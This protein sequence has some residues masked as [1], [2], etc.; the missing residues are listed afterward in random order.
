MQAQDNLKLL[1]KAPPRRRA[2]Y[3]LPLSIVGIIVLVTLLAPVLAPYDPRHAIPDRALHP[4]SLEYLFGT[5]ALGRDV[6]SRTLWGGRQT[7]GVALLAMAITIL[8]GLPV[9]VIAGYYGGW[10]D[11]LLMAGMDTLLA[12]PNL[13]LALALVALIDSGPSQLALAVG[14]AGL[15]AYARVA[16]AAVFKVRGQLYID[17]ARAI[18]ASSYRVLV[19]HILPNIMETLLSFAAVSLSWAILN[20]A[21]LA[22][23]GFS[24]DLAAPDWG[25]MLNQ[26]RAAFRVA[27]WAILP[28]GIAITLTVFAANR[29]ADAWQDMAS[30]H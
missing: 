10:L 5:D 28:P 19:F 11:R 8:P 4:P 1:L 17:A 21:A 7:L 24:G 22:F 12:F 13:L 9:G 18:G 26:G 3:R 20:G 16:R 15:P 23:L 14:I 2:A 27:P 6:Y 30:N 29:L 25:T